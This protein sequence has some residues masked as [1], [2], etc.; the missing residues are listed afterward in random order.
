VVA[1]ADDE[2]PAHACNEGPPRVSVSADKG[3]LTDAYGWSTRKY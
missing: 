1:V 2:R 3:C